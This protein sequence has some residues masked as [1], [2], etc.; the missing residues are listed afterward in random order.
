M[1]LIES[2]I[3]NFVKNQFPSFYQEEGENF[4][5]FVEAYYEWL[6]SENNPVYLSRKIPSIVDIDT[7]LD[8]Y[9][10]HFKEKYLK[11]I[12]F[13]TATNKKLLIKNSLDLFRSKGTPRSVELFFRLIYGTKADVFYP[14]ENIFRL[15]D[16]DWKRDFYLEI[17]QSKKSISLVGKQLTGSISGATAFVEKLIRRKNNNSSI[18]VFYLSNIRGSFVNGETLEYDKLYIDSPRVIG[19]LR[20]FEVVNGGFGFDKGDIVNIISNSGRDGM[21]RITSVSSESGLVD[22]QLFDGGWGYSS[23]A[24][25]IISDKVL[26]IRNFNGELKEFE[27]ITQNNVSLTFTGANSDFAIGDTVYR[28]NSGTEVGRGKILSINQSGATGNLT[29]SIANGSFVNSTSIYSQSNT[30]ILNANVVTDVVTTGKIV[31]YSSNNRLQINVASGTFTKDLE[32]FQANSNGEYANGKIFSVE[33]DILTI[34]N[35]KGFFKTTDVLKTRANSTANLISIT[36]DI[37]VYSISGSFVENSYLKANNFS[38]EILTT[39][40]G[41]GASFKVGTISETE[42][43]FLNTNRLNSNNVNTLAANGATVANVPFMSVNLNSFAYGFPK[44]PQGNSSAVLYSCLTFL[45]KDIGTIENLTSVNPGSDYNKSP[46]VKVVEDSIYPLEKRDIVLELS[47]TSSNFSVGEKLLQT[48]EILNKYLVTVANNANF[49]LGEK[50]YQ[51]TIGSPT[52]NST[53]E[54]IVSNDKLLLTNTEGTISNNNI[55]S[56]TTTANTL[57]SNITVQQLSVSGKGIIKTANSSLVTLKR[58]TYNQPFRVGET[59]TG[60]IT[61]TTAIIDKV[62]EENVNQIGFN[63]NVVGTSI[64]TN[65]YVDSLVVHDSGFG[66]SNNEIVNF[67]SLDGKR[68]GQV[69]IITS[70]LGF[71][72]GQYISTK[73][74]LSEDKFLYDGDY[75]QEYSYEI[76]SK[77]PLEKYSEMFKKVMHIAGTKF[78]GSVEIEISLNSEVKVSS[79]IEGFGLEIPENS[80]AIVDTDGTFLTDSDGYYIIEDA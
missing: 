53:V 79:E 34:T 26:E 6:E 44:N 18:D 62:Y 60:S 32:V 51:G 72:K 54:D 14:G 47:N 48:A 64:I 28:Y 10:V 17:T 15:S 25:V 66:Y 77:I 45:K 21:G 38:G 67:T 13:D 5:R 2:K 41:S 69:K 55:Y 57:I 31:G 7:T 78:F 11:N 27:T 42:S 16:G 19:S 43:V 39:S 23:N 70:G 3:S 59:V 12:Q 8:D 75:Y 65:G 35:S 24:T 29:L 9:I 49:Q 1:K 36:R 50:L 80:V 71:S 22:F 20:N 68:T 56:Y 30:K 33:G 37:G 61:G 73:G 52:S 74:F 4:I 58:I 63:A 46:Y 40:F 76:I